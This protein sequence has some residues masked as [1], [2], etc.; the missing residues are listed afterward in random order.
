VQQQYESIENLVETVH[1]ATPPSNHTF[2]RMIEQLGEARKEVTCLKSEGL[3][4]RIQMKEPMDGYNYTLVL[5]IFAARRD[6]PLHRQL[7][8]LYRQN[9]DF[10]SQNKNLK[11]QLQQSQDEMAQRNLNVLFKDAIEKEK[12]VAKESIAPVKKHV[13]SKEIIAPVKKPIPAKG[14]HANVP[15]GSPPST[16]R[17]VRLMK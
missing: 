15:K 9:R 6:Q 3:S 5:A 7:K 16:R 12:S 4:E 13:S 17:S 14:K 11:A 1:I 2:K 10:Q 8:N